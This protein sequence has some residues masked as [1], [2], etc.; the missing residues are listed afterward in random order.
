MAIS[1]EA[2]ELGKPGYPRR[3]DAVYLSSQQRGVFQSICSQNFRSG[4]MGRGRIYG[5]W[6][7]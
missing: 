5:R 1:T 2:A 6:W 3:P 7:R 4:H